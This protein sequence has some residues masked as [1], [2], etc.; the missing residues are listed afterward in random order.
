[1]DRLVETARHRARSAAGAEW[2]IFGSVTAAVVLTTH[3]VVAILAVGGLTREAGASFGLNPYR[4]A[5]LLDVTVCT[6]PFLLPFFIPTILASSLTAGFDT[7]PRLSPWAAGLHNV[8]SWALLVVVLAA[9]TT[10]WGRRT[11]EMTDQMTRRAAGDL[12]LP[13]TEPEPPARRGGGCRSRGVLAALT[14]A[15][16]GADVVLLEGTDDGGR[17]I[18]ISGGGRCN[19][20]PSVAGPGTLRHLVVAQHAEE[21]PALLAPRRTASFFERE[22]GIALV[23]EEDSGKLFPATDRARDV[24]DA[25]GGPRPRGRRPHLVRRAVVDARPIPNTD[26]RPRGRPGS[27]APPVRAEAV[28]IDDAPPLSA[29]AADP[30]HRRPLRAEDGQ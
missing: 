5:N 7:A 8:H 19:I 21:A 27:D 13:V 11:G 10:G 4:R 16:A 18:L 2:W 14:A 24:R 23:R 3:S 30:R 1:M 20:L 17:K 6:Y 9:I 15:R 25:P 28:E 12:G 26:A 22:L 29:R